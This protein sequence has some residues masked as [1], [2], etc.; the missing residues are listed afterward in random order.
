LGGCC[1]ARKPMERYV[2]PRRSSGGSAL[3][4]RYPTCRQ[5]RWFAMPSG[6]ARYP[7]RS[8]TGSAHK[9]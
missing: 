9:W 2:R 6:R 5:R 1:G 7:R 3:A 8:A 4:R